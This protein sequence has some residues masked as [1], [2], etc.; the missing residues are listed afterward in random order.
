MFRFN[1]AQVAVPFRELRKRCLGDLA[2]QGARLDSLR[3]VCELDALGRGRRDLS[4]AATRVDSIVAR[5]LTQG[6]LLECQQTAD[7]GVQAIRQ[8]LQ[9]L[10]RERQKP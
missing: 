4:R 9:D 1:T 6:W 2:L 3:G 10:E 8:L 5:T 7:R